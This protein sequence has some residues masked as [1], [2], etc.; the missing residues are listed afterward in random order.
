[1]DELNQQKSLEAFLAAKT[2]FDALIAELQV[3]SA[4]HYGADPEAA[5]WEHAEMLE[6]WI[7]R[8]RDMLDE[9]YSREA[10]KG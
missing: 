8:I 5:L 7:R 10:R 2:R 1:M 3:A 4:D 6:G 9:Y